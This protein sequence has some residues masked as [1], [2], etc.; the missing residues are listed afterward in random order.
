MEG[1][2]L[3]GGS[4][5]ASPRKITLVSCAP[6]LNK[7]EAAGRARRKFG[8][9]HFIREDLGGCHCFLVAATPAKFPVRLKGPRGESDH[10]GTRDQRVDLGSRAAG[11]VRDPLPRPVV[12]RSVQSGIPAVAAVGKHSGEL[13]KEDDDVARVARSGPGA[14]PGRDSEA[15][16][17]SGAGRFNTRLQPDPVR[18]TGIM[19]KD[20]PILAL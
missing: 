7:V 12:A 20:A 19:G 5:D 1:W 14:C 6:C 15:D 8:W 16:G 11:G 10:R 3:G 18:G 2:S 9:K 17:Q 13:E 4:T